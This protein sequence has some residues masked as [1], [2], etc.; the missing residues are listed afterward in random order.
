MT[1][2]T[3]PVGRHPATSLI[4]MERGIQGSL[5]DPEG[6]PRHLLNAVGDSPAMQGRQ[7]QRLE[8]E[9]VQR[10]LEDIRG[11]RQF[12]SLLSERKGSMALRHSSVNSLAEGRGTRIFF[13]RSERVPGG[14]MTRGSV[15]LAVLLVALAVRPVRA[16]T[17]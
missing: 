11:G 6:V 7:R 10:A 12:M 15:V 3:A 9:Q 16:Q 8:N 13:L 14:R 2:S 17:V 4:S 5:P 1:R